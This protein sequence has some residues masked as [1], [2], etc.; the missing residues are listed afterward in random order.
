MTDEPRGTPETNP[1]SFSNSWRSASFA[2][3]LQIIGALL[4]I[5]SLLLVW[6]QLRANNKTNKVSIRGQLYEREVEMAS[7]EASEHVLNTM[8]ALVPTNVRTQ[9]YAS[10]LLRLVTSDPAVLRSKSAAQLYHAMYDVGTLSNPGR[11]AATQDLRT[12]YLYAQTNLYHVH[13]A[14]DYKRDKILGGPEWETWKGL[15]RESHAHPV[16]IAT[17][18][19]GYQNRYF[20]RSFGLFLQAELLRAGP[21]DVRDLKTFDRDREFICYYYSAMCNAHWAVSLPDY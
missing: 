14:L 12:L 15:L 4:T 3:R 10:T 21:T 7:D 9:A 5:F 17:I 6:G 13:M 11:R 16:L 20:S 19:Q 1:R 2:D 18:W 8:W